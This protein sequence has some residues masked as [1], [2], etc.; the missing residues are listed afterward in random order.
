MA[1]KILVIDGHPESDRA[2]FCHALA[3]AYLKGAMEAGKE[4]RLITLAETPVEFLRSA[5]DF[6]APPR[7]A[8][9]KS[10]QAD[11]L[12]ADHIVLIFPL[13]LSGAPALL[14]AFLE[15]VACGGFFAETA[16]P[17]IRPKFKGKSAR[18]IV[19]MGMPAFVYRLIFRA[20]RVRNI[21][22]GVLGFAG[23]S[24][25]RATMFGAVQTV[26]TEQHKLRLDRAHMLGRDGR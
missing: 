10:A 22:S 23:F 16:G 21:M 5:R 12:W 18:L 9:M 1:Q 26:D 2:R 15:Q 4:T 13:W 3:D 6:T 14:H 25:A 19:T 24:P 20:H 8:E 7:T 17:G 11:F